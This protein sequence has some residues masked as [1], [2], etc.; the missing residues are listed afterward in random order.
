M[1]GRTIEELQVGDWAEMTRVVTEADVRGFAQV[2]GDHNP[3]HFDRV[4]AKR[5]LFKG[6]IA[7][8]IL[9]AGFISAVIGTK[10]PGP[11]SIYLSQE[12]RFLRPVRRGDALTARVIVE[13]IVADKNRIRLR[14]VCLNQRGEEVITGAA[15]VMPP[16]GRMVFWGE[17]PAEPA[18]PNWLPTLERLMCISWAQVW[19]QTVLASALAGAAMGQLWARRLLTSGSRR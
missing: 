11:G 2:S 7:H 17:V 15:L 9:T 10:L 19:Q 5:T 13:E 8:G 1:V 6:P 16:E 14:T 3:L 4:F 18:G 12:L